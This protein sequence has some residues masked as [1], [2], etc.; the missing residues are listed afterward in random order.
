MDSPELLF[1]HVP[2]PNY[3]YVDG[4]TS[5]NP[6]PGGF[7]ITDHSGKILFQKEYYDIHTN[8][9]YELAAIAAAAIKCPGKIIW[10]D[11]ITAIAWAKNRMGKEARRKYVTDESFKAMVITLQMCNPTIYKWQTGKWSAEIPADPGR[12]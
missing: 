12:K 5:G 8:N 4:W 3:V 2:E 10:S 6:G 7:I 9:W 11:S 1:E